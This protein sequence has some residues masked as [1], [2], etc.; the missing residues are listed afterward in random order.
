MSNLITRTA[1][2]IPKREMAE[3][4]GTVERAAEAL[5][6]HLHKAF[7]AIRMYDANHPT[8][9]GSLKQLFQSFDEFLDTHGELHL[10][11]TES[12]ILFHDISL[13]HEENR[14]GGLIFMMFN[15]GIREMRFEPG[16]TCDEIGELLKAL[17][18][19]SRLPQE[20]RD[21]VGLF[22]SKEFSHI[23]YMAVEEIPDEEIESVDKIIADVE[24]RWKDRDGTE[25]FSRDEE[26]KSWN[27]VS[28]GEKHTVGISP[29][30]ATVSQLKSVN[31]EMIET[32]LQSVDRERHFDSDMELIQIIFDVLHSENEEDRYLLAVKLLA[33]YSD[34]LLAKGD[35]AQ[36]NHIVRKLKTYIER[37]RTRTSPLWRHADVLLSKFSRVEKLALLQKGLKDLPSDQQDELRNFLTLLNPTVI[38]PM[39]TFLGGIEDE[40]TRRT[41]CAG[42]AVLATG[43][44]SRLAK[45][46]QNEPA[47]IARN[48]VTI[49]QHIGDDNA[50]A[51]L[52]AC[53]HHEHVTVREEAVRALRALEN[54]RAHEA[55]LEFLSDEDSTI[56]TT[57]AEGLDSFKEYGYVDSLLKI[58]H[59]K[60]FTK[61]SYR[62]KKAILAVLGNVK[63]RESIDTLETLLNKRGL[64]RR[65]RQN[66]TRAC[67]ALALAKI[68]SERARRLLKRFSRDSSGPVRQ[69]CKQALLTGQSRR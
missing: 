50:I 67:A 22:W 26:S 18:E 10:Q 61:R 60:T 8:L 3:A 40:R 14:R 42:L 9:H 47:K 56:R 27:H 11:F 17:G 52:K 25:S 59:Q 63:C 28:D 29:P 31:Q 57:A 16:L 33:D 24:S 21:I 36:V 6:F 32:L 39:C 34:E 38:G 20:E 46:L 30:P 7:A 65:K 58:A 55:L 62:E 69:A 54:V 1:P 53:V 35:F 43:Q 15:D 12:E 13:Y 44:T 68:N 41:I 2:N 19:N 4:E 64:F 51:L 37:Y 66:E 49:L 48:I 5:I 23:H 45:P